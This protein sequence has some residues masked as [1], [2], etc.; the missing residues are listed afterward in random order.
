MQSTSV[1]TVQERICQTCKIDISTY[2]V[3][4]KRCRTCFN[5]SK[6][7]GGCDN[8]GERID[9]T[10]LSSPNYCNKCYPSVFPTHNTVSSTC[11]TCG[12][13]F[14][15]LSID[16]YKTLCPTCR[17]TNMEKVEDQLAKQGYSKKAVVW[18][19][20]I[21][22]KSQSDGVGKEGIKIKHALNGGEHT[23]DIGIYK[24][25]FD[26]YCKETNTVYEFYGD[27]WHGNPR[28]YRP[29]DLVVGNKTANELYLRTKWREEQI[30]K[31]GYNLVTMWE[32]DFDKM[33]M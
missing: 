15:S 16:M 18:L 10:S 21:M 25:S 28:V 17:P 1:E 29:E 9:D 33:S 26:G 19:N 14:L 3:R 12:K 30:L 6:E 13:R 27:R 5:S 23:V 7:D 24:F 4:F 8:C 32:Y 22:T 20:T 2:P 11:F 31:A